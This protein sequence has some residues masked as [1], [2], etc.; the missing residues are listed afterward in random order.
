MI[1][2]TVS[3][4]A[5]WAPDLQTAEAWQDWAC[6][7][8]LP[9]GDATP[10]L[11]EVPAMQRRRIERLGRM[12]VQV[13]YWCSRAEAD[14]VPLVF[15]SRHGD[16]QR[17]L[18]LLQQQARGE[19]MSPTQF[20]LSVHN[21]IAALYSIVRGE[22]GNYLAL[23]GGKASAEAALIEACGLLAEGEDEVLVV[24]YDAPLPDAYAAFADEAEAA[25]AWCWRLR[26]T[27]AGV[28]LSLAWATAA[29]AS[30]AD[31]ARALPAGLWPLHFLLAGA[32]SAGR[33]AEGLHWHWQRHG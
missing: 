9:Q 5:A 22:H 18:E 4:W 16:V 31:A 13:A 24:V 14:G 23:A 19:P 27:G 10:A 26:A 32:P 30:P 12:A 20:G 8:W 3:Q 21:A 2:F 25:Y 6:A 11:P 33:Q 7:P 28:A 29:D 1:E 15:A 17:S